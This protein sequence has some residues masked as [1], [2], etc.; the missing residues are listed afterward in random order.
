MIWDRSQHPSLCDTLNAVAFKLGDTVDEE[1]R[2]ARGI[3]SKT[4]LRWFRY[5]LSRPLEENT[6]EVSL[7]GTVIARNAFGTS[8]WPVT[9]EIQCADGAVW[10]I[11]YE[12]ESPY[13]AFMGRRVVASGFP[14][15]AP[16]HCR[17]MVTGH[18][19]V[20]RMHLAEETADAWLTEVG[21]A[22][23]LAGRFEHSIEGE[24]AESEF[25]FVTEHGDAF[26]VI[27][28]PAGMAVDQFVETLAYPVQLSPGFSRSVRQSLWV[29]CPIS[30]EQ[31]QRR[32]DDPTGGL[33]NDVYLDVVN[34]QVRSRG[35]GQIG[36]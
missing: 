6:P 3:A 34:G 26:Q 2:K 30:S 28:N 10:V 20:S 32:R 15:G 13:H 36:G 21:A 27:N 22:Q 33:P 35:A 29:I 1:V 23:E 4:R 9:T 7:E 16:L 24:A 12:E 25:S 11:D 31:L 8:G 14:C 18:F 19:A 17:I 5:R